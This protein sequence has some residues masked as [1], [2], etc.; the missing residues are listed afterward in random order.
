M[1]PNDDAQP[2]EW[3]DRALK[4]PETILE[5]PAV[6]RALVKAHERA[7]GR[8]VVDL[9]GLAMDRLEARLERLEDAHRTVVANAYDNV[10]GTQQ[11]HRAVLAVLDAPDAD[12]ILDV[13]AGEF[14][15]LLRIEAVRL[16][17]EC[18]APP[19]HSIV[20]CRRPGAVRAMLGIPDG[21]PLRP[22]TLRE[23]VPS[24]RTIH[25][26]AQVRSEAMIVLDL[27]AAPALLILGSSEAALFR[28]G[29]GTDLLAFLGGCVARALRRSA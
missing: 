6:M 25:G 10:A 29:Q 20:A 14:A 1:T 12:G 13:L 27:G 18:D 19:P 21:V 28:P 5:D 4:A 15:T 16:V 17:M 7:R 24:D 8:N 3:R 2:R 9:R 22:V 23:G 11:I 26:A